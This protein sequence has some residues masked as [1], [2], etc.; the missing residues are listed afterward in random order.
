MAPGD[1]VF[2]HPAALVIFVCKRIG[3]P[4]ESWEH[5]R[6]F[7]IQQRQCG[8]DYGEFLILMSRYCKILQVIGLDDIGTVFD[9][10]SFVTC[11]AAIITNRVE[12]RVNMEAAFVT[13]RL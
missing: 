5:R 6:Y 11:C 13:S 12:G 9:G 4:G 7:S 10:G 8:L 3:S 2:R 1:G